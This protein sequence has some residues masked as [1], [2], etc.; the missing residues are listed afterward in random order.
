MCKYTQSFFYRF[1]SGWGLY[2]RS[3]FLVLD[4][5]HVSFASHMNSLDPTKI[6]ILYKIIKHV[7]NKWPCLFKL[8]VFRVLAGS[9][10]LA[11]LLSIA[12]FPF[13]VAIHGL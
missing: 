5:G 10:Q 4:V 7:T 9:S 2:Q 13:Q 8:N 1:R 12:T 3:P 11:S 6:A